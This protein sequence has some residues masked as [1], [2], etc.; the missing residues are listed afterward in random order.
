MRGPVRDKQLH[1]HL[2]ANVMR[3]PMRAATCIN[4]GC[5]AKSRLHAIPS[6][7]ALNTE[8]PV[9]GAAGP[10]A[11]L[12]RRVPARRR[13]REGRRHG[14][15]Q[16]RPALGLRRLR[17][18][19]EAER[20]DGGVGRALQQGASASR[21]A[22]V[23]GACPIERLADGVRTG[24]R[25]HS[26][27][28]VGARSA[29]TPGATENNQGRS[30]SPQH[31]HGG[32]GNQRRLPSSLKDGS[33][34]LVRPHTQAL[35]A[36]ANDLR[37]SRGPRREHRAPL[38]TVQRPAPVHTMELSGQIVRKPVPIT[39]RVAA[40]VAA[41]GAA[42][43]PVAAR[44]PALA[45]RLPPPL[46]RSASLPRLRP[47][48][49][50]SP[51]FQFRRVSCKTATCGRS[52]GAAANV[53]RA[54]GRR[55]LRS[56]AGLVQIGLQLHRSEPA[57]NSEQEK[58]RMVTIQR[59]ERP[60]SGTCSKKPALRWRQPQANLL[61]HSLAPHICTRTLLGKG[62]LKHDRHARQ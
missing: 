47:R 39:N 50:V 4:I 56:R 23:C 16:G 40:P 5:A 30:W 13:Q 1:N 43:V 8:A 38:V 22:C 31:A 60:L 33:R 20:A 52:L 28:N 42:P 58:Q 54:T 57:P 62:W 59:P 7:A 21:V 37:T 26:Q 18:R 9:A 49:S 11:H 3:S 25:S 24:L 2:M 15:R 6:R 14:R 12:G 51:L 17:A 45:Q 32:H 46:S 35:H 55:H 36:C 34:G 29:L 61:N 48:A 44:P 10:R 41:P 27:P 53:L 19:V